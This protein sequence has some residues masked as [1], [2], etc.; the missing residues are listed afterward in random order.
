MTIQSLFN[1]K[2]I[3]TLLINAVLVYFFAPGVAASPHEAGYSNSNNGQLPVFLSEQQPVEQRPFFTQSSQSTSGSYTIERIHS[4]WQQARVNNKK[5]ML[6]L[7][8][9]SCDRCALLQRY[10]T[11][12]TMSQRLASR[13]IILGID[14]ANSDFS[15]AVGETGIPQEQLPAILLLNTVN[16]FEQTMQSEEVLAF[17][18]EPYEPIYQWIEN[19]IHYTD[20]K[21]AAL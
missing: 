14:V 17:L 15:I 11:E 5:I 4:A 9:D 21:L 1:T 13:Y 16:S 2:S 3:K 18:P 6:V 19:I 12:D 8:S 20:Q 7:G 10:V